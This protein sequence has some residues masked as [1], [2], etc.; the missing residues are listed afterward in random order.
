MR[1]FMTYVDST[2]INGA[3][4]AQPPKIIVRLINDTYVPLT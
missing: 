4:K 2:D 1:H 3:I